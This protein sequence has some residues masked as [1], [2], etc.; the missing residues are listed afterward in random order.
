MFSS[1]ESRIPDVTTHKGL[2]QAL[3]WAEEAAKTP[4]TEVQFSGVRACVLTNVQIDFNLFYRLLK[5]KPGLPHSKGS[6]YIRRTVEFSEILAERGIED[7]AENRQKLE[8]DI[9]NLMCSISMKSD[10]GAAMFTLIDRYIRQTHIVQFAA[11]TCIDDVAAKLQET[12]MDA[13]DYFKVLLSA[14]KNQ[15]LF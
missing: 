11:F 8:N 1:G 9:H 13:R 6:H 12:G 5:I 4:N 15:P 10:K 7:T 3:R 2:A 14:S